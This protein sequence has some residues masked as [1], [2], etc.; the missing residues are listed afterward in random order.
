MRRLHRTIPIR[1][2][3]RR[4]AVPLYD[5]ETRA[6]R[7]EQGLERLV[8]QAK[9]ELNALGIDTTGKLPFHLVAM[10]KAAK[11]KAGNTTAGL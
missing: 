8:I 9:S 7:L 2:T 3:D 11:R 5:L 6:A 10:A 4:K 1:K